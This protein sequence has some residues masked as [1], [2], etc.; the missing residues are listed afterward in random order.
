ML[1]RLN[2]ARDMI[3]YTDEKISVIAEEVG[4]SNL[5][6]FYTHIRNYFN[7]TPSEMRLQEEEKRRKE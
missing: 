6:Y 4:Y 1:Y 3:L 7:M 5:N 2:T